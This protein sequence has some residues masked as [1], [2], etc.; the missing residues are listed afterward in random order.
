MTSVEIGRAAEDAALCHLE[1]A[2][3][4]LIT[5]NYRIR[6]REID[7]I[8][9]DTNTLV[10]IEVRYRRNTRF[11]TGLE[12][13]TAAK[14]AR[15]VR[16]A[17]AYLQTTRQSDRNCRFDIVSITGKPGSFEVDWIRNAFNG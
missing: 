11:G 7:L 3:L 6:A 1:G 13:V 16:T 12:S 10:F 15:I 5:R 2:G 4:D 9:S 8:M 14:T 17:S